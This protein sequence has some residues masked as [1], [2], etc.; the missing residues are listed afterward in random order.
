MRR[1]L[2]TCGLVLGLSLL[3]VPRASADTFDLNDVYCNCLPAGSSDGGT[4]TLTD[5]G[6]DV[7]FTVNLNDLLNFHYNNAFDLFAFNYSG[8]FAESSFSVTGQP[9]GWNLYTTPINNSSMN[10]AGKD[11][12][13]FIRCEDVSCSSGGGGISGVN[14]LTFVLHSS[15]GALDLLPFETT[16][17][18]TGTNNNDFAVAGTL[19][20]QSGCTGVIGGGNGTGNSTPQASSGVNAEG[21]SCVGGTNVPDGG[22]TISLLGIGM[23]GLGYLKRRVS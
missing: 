2:L 10:G 18:D 11:Y 16:V 22:G 8:A 3:I 6:A 21:Q 23:L 5:L 9:A 20:N 1:L 13:L 17:G 14:V 4:V 19:I 7:Q 15:A 12:D